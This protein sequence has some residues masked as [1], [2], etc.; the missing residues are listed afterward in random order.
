M[1]KKIAS[2]RSPEQD[3]PCHHVA[4][5]QAIPVSAQVSGIH[6]FRRPVPY[7]G[8]RGAIASAWSVGRIADD[9]DAA[10][11]LA[12]GGSLIFVLAAELAAAAAAGPAG[13]PAL[14]AGW[15]HGLASLA[16]FL[17]FVVAGWLLA[18]LRWAYS[19]PARR[20]TIG[21]LWDVGTFWP[22]AVHPLAPP[23]YAERTVPEIVDRIRLLTGHLTNQPDDAAELYALAGQQKLNR[24]PPAPPAV[25][26]DIPVLLMDRCVDRCR[27]T[28][29]R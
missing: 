25:I 7:A 26:R 13:Q 5:P 24:V 12:V 21:V 14:L 15:W 20:R 3:S 8:N 19:D 10:A 22:R 16:A 9:A 29:A 11:G 27:R 1:A 4:E 6:T 2:E 17:G 23:C 28:V 18:L